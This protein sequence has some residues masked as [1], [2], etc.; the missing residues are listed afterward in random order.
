LSRKGT[1]LSEPRGSEELVA[2]ARLVEEGNDNGVDLRIDA[3]DPRNR[4]F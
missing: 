4:R 1:P 2:S 3:L